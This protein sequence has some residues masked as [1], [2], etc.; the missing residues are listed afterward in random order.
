M[1]F[2]SRFLRLSVL[3]WRRERPQIA[4][5][6]LEWLGRLKCRATA[7][8]DRCTAVAFCILPTTPRAPCLPAL[9]RSLGT[10]QSSWKFWAFQVL[11]NLSD[12]YRK[13]DCG[14]RNRFGHKIS[15]FCQVCE[16]ASDIN[17]K[18]QEK[19]TVLSNFGP[20]T[21]QKDS[22]WPRLDLGQYYYI[23]P[24]VMWKVVAIFA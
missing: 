10:R 3:P 9:N 21:L 8:W 2:C 20:K 19:Q 17:Q 5:C 13:S 15:F 14:S 24:S 4:M 16:E 23:N 18:T 1:N 7:L 12:M 22:T 6:W 11:L